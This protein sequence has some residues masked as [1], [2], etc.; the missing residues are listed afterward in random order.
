MGNA[1][2]KHTPEYQNE[3]YWIH[4]ASSDKDAA[5]AQLKQMYGIENPDTLKDSDR[6]KYYQYTRNVLPKDRVLM[7]EWN[8]LT[9]TERDETRAELKTQWGIDDK[10]PGYALMRGHKI[11]QNLPLAGPN[12]SLKNAGNV[13]VKTKHDWSG[14]NVTVDGKK[15]TSFQPNYD[16][17]GGNSYQAMNRGQDTNFLNYIVLGTEEYNKEQ[18]EPAFSFHT[19]K[20]GFTTAGKGLAKVILD[21]VGLAI[22][23]GRG[24]SGGGISGALG[25]VNDSVEEYD[26]KGIYMDTAINLATAGAAKVAGTTAKMAVNAA[27]GVKSVVK[28]GLKASS[29]AEDSVAQ[30]QAKNIKIEKTGLKKVKK[31]LAKEAKGKT[32]IETETDNIALNISKDLQEAERVAV[33]EA[34]VA[35]EEAAAMAA[36]KQAELDGIAKRT[37]EEQ[38]KKN[39]ILKNQIADGIYGNDPEEII[40]PGSDALAG[41]GVADAS[42]ADKKAIQ[43]ALMKEQERL[44]ILRREGGE[45]DMM[46]AAD[47][48]ANAVREQPGELPHFKKEGL[49]PNHRYRDPKHH[50]ELVSM[51]MAQDTYLPLEKRAQKI[52]NF[53]LIPERSNYN[54]SVYVDSASKKIHVSHRGSETGYDWAVSDSQILF[55]QEGALEN[56]VNKVVGEADQIAGGLKVMANELEGAV[57][58]NPLS[59]GTKKVSG[60]VEYVGKKIS[61]IEDRFTRS[62]SQIKELGALTEEGGEYAGYTIDQSGHSLGGQVA[63]YPAL[64]LR[65]KKYMGDVYTFNGAASPPSTIKMASKLTRAEQEKLWEKVH[66]IRMNDDLVSVSRQPFGRVSTLNLGKGGKID[67]KAHHS[68]ITF[69]DDAIEHDPDNF[70]DLVRKELI[71][72]DDEIDQQAKM[73]EQWQIRYDM[74]ARKAGQAGKDVSKLLEDSGDSGDYEIP[75]HDDPLALTLDG[76]LHD[77][78]VSGHKGEGEGDDAPGGGDKKAAIARGM[79]LKSIYEDEEE[80]EEVV[81]ASIS[82]LEEIDISIQNI[83]NDGTTFRIKEEVSIDNLNNLFLNCI[84]YCRLAQKPEEVGILNDFFVLEVESTKTMSEVLF[85]KENN[86][87][88][89][90]FSGENSIKDSIHAYFREQGNNRLPVITNLKSLRTR[91]GAFSQYSLDIRMSRCVADALQETY[92]KIFQFIKSIQTVNRIIVTGEGVGGSVASAF[93]YL[94]NCDRRKNL[95]FPKISHNVTFG[96]LAFVYN[97]G[98]SQDKYNNATGRVKNLRAF[99]SNDILSYFPLPVEI[100]NNFLSTE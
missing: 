23:A 33:A 29:A 9:Q 58:K 25:A 10:T 49:S 86:S 37:A 74:Y 66:N 2:T 26:E 22:D 52:G 31:A 54:T 71:F 30:A 3:T 46:G 50:Y 73:I 99:N 69:M 24:L 90:I 75:H 78:K 12:Y 81:S 92:E 70:I 15:L 56:T 95:R 51:N 61:K 20:D 7:G 32:K 57:G 39:E 35:E 4:S 43:D 17:G 11:I 85:R 53:T 14:K 68:M 63:N 6:W 65:D 45:R 60:G 84:E 1:G 82:E 87:L 100:P 62:Q 38:I 77:G 94:Y 42:A 83:E 93:N 16:S 36:A 28:A 44:N 19:L 55:A 91:I 88:Y 47:A 80:E 97:D 96:E 13:R 76:I 48:E 59:E 18:G 72:M 40:M 8:R 64:A 5:N 21:P 27:K 67:P 89:I 41:S 79:A 34:A 98:V